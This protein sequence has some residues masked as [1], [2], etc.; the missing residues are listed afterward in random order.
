MSS[1]PIVA[2]IRRI[3]E[4]IA[5]EFNYDLHA[6]VKDAQQ[7]DAA[8]DRLVVRREPRPALK[9]ISVPAKTA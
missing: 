1:D 6:M 3:R 8:G 7:R 2:E 9:P 5:A 4:Q